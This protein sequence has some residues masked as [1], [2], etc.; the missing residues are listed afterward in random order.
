[1]HAAVPRH[2]RQCFRR[3]QGHRSSS[4]GVPWRARAERSSTSIR[5]YCAASERPMAGRGA[6]V[7]SGLHRRQMWT[8]LGQMCAV[9]GR[10]RSAAQ[11]DMKTG[12][13]SCVF[14]S[15]RHESKEYMFDG[16]PSSAAELTSKQYVQAHACIRASIRTRT[17]MCTRARTRTVPSRWLLRGRPMSSQPRGCRSASLSRVLRTLRAGYTV[18]AA[19]RTS[20][21]T[22]AGAPSQLF[23]AAFACTWFRCVLC[24]G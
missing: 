1:L 11:V 24:V 13:W 2:R 3:L 10:P 12:G 18:C 19:V 14:C 8:V 22:F 20:A 7:T 9:V 15:K 6:Q 4:G 21:C 17:H 16:T 23:C 5:R